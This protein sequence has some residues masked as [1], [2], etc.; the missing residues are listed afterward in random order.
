M[1]AAAKTALLVAIPVAA[2]VGWAAARVASPGDAS[3]APDD[4]KTMETLVARVERLERAGEVARPAAS[5]DERAVARRIEAIETKLADASEP[6]Q[7]APATKPDAATAASADDK[8]R[9]EV[10]VGLATEPASDG[11]RSAVK[12]L[13]ERLVASVGPPFAEKD[14]AW[15]A[16]LLDRE[17]RRDRVTVQEAE[18]MAPVLFALPTGHA[19]RPV[20]AKAVAAGWGRDQRLASFFDKLPSNSEPAV[21]QGVLSVLDDEHPSAAFSEYVLRILREERDP[22]VL[23]TAMDLDRIEAAATASA[24]PRIVSTIETRIVEGTLDAKMRSRA[25]LAIGVAALRIPETGVAT[26]RRLADRET[27]AKV[28]ERLRQAATTL[29]EGNATLKSLERIFE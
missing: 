27:D 23:S 2:V 24:A 6:T 29:A 13:A 5:K 14:F 18:E 11:H 22:A 1:N 20:L 17:A 8:A 21:H 4:A 15:A 12:R 7:A 9:Q 16:G 19:G 10:V 3:G 28:Q 26:L 25:G